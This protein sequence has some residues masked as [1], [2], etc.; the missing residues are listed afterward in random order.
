M[1][2]SVLIFKTPGLVNYKTFLSINVLS[3]NLCTTS[4]Q[5][6]TMSQDHFQHA[7]NIYSGREC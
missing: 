3:L 2:P 1:I 5:S 7:E 6:Y 4:A